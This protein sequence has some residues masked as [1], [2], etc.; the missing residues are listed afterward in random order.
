M[1]TSTTQHDAVGQQRSS[2]RTAVDPFQV[3]YPEAELTELRRRIRR[4]AGPS[5]RRSPTIRRACRSRRFRS[6]RA[7]GG[8][9]TTGPS[10][11]RPE[12]PP[13][14]H[15]RDRRAG[16]SF[17][18]R[19]LKARRCPAADHHARVARLDHRAAEGHRPADRPDGIRR[20]RVGRLRCGHPSL[21]GYGF[22]GKPTSTGWG[23]PRTAGAWVELM[24][25]LGYARFVAQGGDWGAAVTQAM[26]NRQPRAARHS[27]QHARYRAAR[28][29]DGFEHGIPPPSGLSDDE[30]RAYGS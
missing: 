21:P 27:L 8:R 15:H 1:S 2:D 26:E 7:T 18:S 19:S 17:H 20:E 12:R 16:H 3:D 28:S 10:A 4:H 11:R 29:Q 9:T 5:V 23:P 22:S 13:A 24:K 25:R 14:V 30:A 6:S